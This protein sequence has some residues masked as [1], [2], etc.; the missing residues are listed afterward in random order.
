MTSSAIEFARSLYEA[1]ARGDMPWM[2]EHMHPDAVFHQTGRFPTAGTY[3]GRDAVFGHL[4]E[5]MQLVEGNFS[6][7]VHDIAA[8]DQHLVALI[9]VTVGYGS[10]RLEFDEA[11]IFH[12]MDGK[13]TEMWAVPQNPYKVDAFF[14]GVTDP[15]TT[16][17]G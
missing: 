11:H 4:G 16:S 17:G 1:M 2:Y 15:Q 14:A 7:D 3:R 5:F 10:R 13:V 12:L 6:I 9:R 8:S